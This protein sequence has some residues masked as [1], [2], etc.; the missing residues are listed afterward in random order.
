MDDKLLRLPDVVK[1]T[2]NGRSTI[3]QLIKLGRF[4]RQVKISAGG[5]S[6]AWLASEVETWLKNR[7]IE[8]DALANLAGGG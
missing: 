2:G 8:R 3:Y 4:P 7:A 5:K 6:S 1:A